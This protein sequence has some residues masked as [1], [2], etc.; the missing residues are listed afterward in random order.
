[1]KRRTKPHVRML[2]EDIPTLWCEAGAVVWLR[3]QRI[4]GGG[5]KAAAE[6]RLM[7]DEK[8]A[9][10]QDLMGR[11]LSGKLGSDPLAITANATRY[12]VKGVRAN[13]RRLSR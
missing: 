7:I 13:R 3:S 1:M 6:A 11:L 12:L 9:A 4:L 5:P 8:I 10:Q 2:A